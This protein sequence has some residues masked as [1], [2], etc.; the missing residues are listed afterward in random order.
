MRE[1]LGP[2]NLIKTQAFYIYELINVIIAIRNENHIFAAFHVVVTNL[3]HFNYSS[4]LL[5]LNFIQNFYKYFLFC[6][7]S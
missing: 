3:K 5:I 2:A 7:K 4:K 1:F 6:K